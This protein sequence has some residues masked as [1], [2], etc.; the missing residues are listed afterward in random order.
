MY[1]NDL[2]QIRFYFDIIGNQ[3]IAPKYQLIGKDALSWLLEK[4]A[5]YRGE[6]YISKLESNVVYLSKAWEGINQVITRYLYQGGEIFTNNIRVNQYLAAVRTY[7]GKM[8]QEAYID[9]LRTE[10]INL[11][12][13]VD[14]G[15]EKIRIDNNIQPVYMD[16]D[17]GIFPNLRA[18][19][20]R[21]DWRMYI[22]ELEFNCKFFQCALQVS[23]NY[24][25]YFCTNSDYKSCG[26]AF[27]LVQILEV[28]HEKTYQRAI[29]AANLMGVSND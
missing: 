5:E 19:R 17:E 1:F 6:V 29:L 21:R 14:P 15:L 22:D 9:Y 28:V 26:S 3:L 24:L 18:I 20:K 8:Y 16:F 11:K 23:S 12:K 4:Q 13:T 27:T 7:F 2:G 25:L 10:K